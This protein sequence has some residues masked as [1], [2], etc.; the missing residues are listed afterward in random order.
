MAVPSPSPAP[1]KAK[2]RKDLRARRLDYVRGL[3]ANHRR[4]EERRLAEVLRDLVRGARCV[5]GYAAIGG[6]IDP[7]H[8]LGLAREAAL[9]HFE[10]R[11]AIF[12]FRSGPPVDVG[13]HH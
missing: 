10:H 7:A 9:P 4:E 1:T 2:L 13:P 12:T 3:S 5:G 8:A 11:S 6:E